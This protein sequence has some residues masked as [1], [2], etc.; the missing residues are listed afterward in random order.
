MFVPLRHQQLSVL[1]AFSPYFTCFNL[2]GNA[3]GQDLP[4]A[5]TFE[6]SKV[7]V[8]DSRYVCGPGD[9]ALGP[10]GELYCLVPA[11]DAVK[12][13]VPGT[14]YL[15]FSKDGGDLWSEPVDVTGFQATYAPTYP[16]IA[17]APSGE[18]VIFY[19]DPITFNPTLQWARPLSTSFSEGVILDGNHLSVR[20]YPKA[21]I[22]RFGVIHVAWST[23]A[24]KV[25]YA[26]SE[27]TPFAA[28]DS[29]SASQQ[30]DGR[31]PGWVPEFRKVY[32]LSRKSTYGGSMGTL[33]V[34]AGGASL[35][36]WGES[37]G[38]GTGKGLTNL[39]RLERGER[40][41]GGSYLLG[42]Q[43]DWSL[44]KGSLTRGENELLLLFDTYNT[45]GGPYFQSFDFA[46]GEAPVPRPIAEDLSTALLAPKPMAW[47]PRGELCVVYQ[48]W[49]GVNIDSIRFVFSQDGGMTWSKPV[50]ITDQ[51]GGFVADLVVDRHGTLHIVFYDGLRNISYIRGHL[52]R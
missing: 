47:G 8:S 39:F 3:L 50:Q 5:P 34:T 13:T 28:P 31:L 19:E 21:E 26:R 23:A 40:R 35:S 15:T 9:L 51:W 45:K 49:D 7:L 37:L 2:C 32:E 29:G 24:G 42:S 52:Y 22:D 16:A 38:L 17:V 30:R 14:Y 36:I 33:A 25:F 41:G 12:H 20:V 18:V 44:Y 27:A 6:A 46:T 4:L 48:N 10:E 1:L 11:R 43:F